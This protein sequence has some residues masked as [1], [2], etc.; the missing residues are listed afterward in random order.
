M[1]T[2]AR[3]GNL[4]YHMLL[5]FLDDNVYRILYEEVDESEVKIFNFP[6]S[7]SAGSGEI[8]Q[9]RYNYYKN[10]LFSLVT[11]VHYNFLILQ[12]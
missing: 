5:F 3:E 11:H 8:E 6:S 12:N 2:C 9:Y 7:N 4:N 10:K 1:P